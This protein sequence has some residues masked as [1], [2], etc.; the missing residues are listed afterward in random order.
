MS[1]SKLAGSPRRKWG[2]PVLPLNFFRAKRERTFRWGTTLFHT[3]SRAAEH[4]VPAPRIPDVG[5]YRMEDVQGCSGRQ[6]GYSVPLS[7]DVPSSTTSQLLVLWAPCRASTSTVQSTIE[8]LGALQRSRFHFFGRKGC[9]R[10][11]RPILV[12][13]LVKPQARPHS[14]PFHRVNLC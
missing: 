6:C 2:A 12:L 9:R 10:G 8:T 1:I 14:N 3:F 13:P 7:S 5:M 11:S 4:V